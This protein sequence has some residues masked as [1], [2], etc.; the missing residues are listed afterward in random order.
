[1]AETFVND[2]S[3]KTVSIVEKE[4]SGLL[5]VLQKAALVGIEPAMFN[6]W[7]FDIS[8]APLFAKRHRGAVMSVCLFLQLSTYPPVDLSDFQHD[9]SF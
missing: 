9:N 4:N 3:F 7:K 8:S 5:Q 6:R 2:L 1:M